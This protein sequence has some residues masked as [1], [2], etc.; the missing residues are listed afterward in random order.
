ML[1]LNLIEPYNFPLMT[2]ASSLAQHYLIEAWKWSFSD[3]MAIADPDFVNQTHVIEA[4]VSKD[5][6][7]QLRQKFSSTTT[8]PP[9]H[10]AD[11]VEPVEQ[12]ILDSGTTHF[13]VV[14]SSRNIVGLTSTVNLYFGSKILSPST[15]IILNDE[16]DDFST[17]NST[18]AFGQP[19]SVAN[20]IAPYKKPISSMTPTLVLANDKP[21]LTIGGSGGTRIIT[22]V[23]QVVSFFIL[24]RENQFTNFI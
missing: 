1:T 14:D 11:L 22:A 10:Y 9:A 2:N 6:A 24:K 3:R 4:M 16:M 8:Y 7:A 18:N 23:I 13:S 12:S 5:H 21:I 17:P 19:P 20:Y 15:G